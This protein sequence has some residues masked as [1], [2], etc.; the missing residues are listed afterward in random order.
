MWLSSEYKKMNLV[1][2]LIL[3]SYRVGIFGFAASPALQAEH[4]LNSGLLDQRLGLDWVQ[5]N[6][7][8]FGGDPAQVTIFG[9]SAGAYSVGM[10]V[11]S[12]GGDRPVPFKRA[13]M[14][15][16]S[17][18]GQTGITA[19]VAFNHTAMMTSLTNCT[20][21]DHCS[22]TELQ[23][24]RNLPLS[25]LLQTV[26]PFEFGI[27]PFGAF[28]VWPPT[29]PSAF[30]P[31]APS[32]LLHKGK[33]AKN[34]DLISGWCENDGS[35]FVTA[36]VNL[37]T[38]KE[39]LSYFK[40]TYPGL[41]KLSLQQM[42]LLYPV[43]SFSSD[44]TGTPTSQYFR[45]AQIDRDIHF[46]CPALLMTQAMAN[47]S[48]HH[49]TTFVYTLNETLFA[50]A[51]SESGHGYYGV[52]HLSDI[53]YVFN[54]ASSYGALKADLDLASRISGSWVAFARTGM[55][56]TA[57]SDGELTIENWKQST[58]AGANGTMFSIDV[59]GGP[60]PGMT[61]IRSTGIGGPLHHENIALRCLFW[62][63]ETVLE[64]LAT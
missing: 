39:L 23:C 19:G 63:Q 11:L 27:N 50:N 10:Q 47:F 38:D 31:D 42:L 52:S 14:E 51:F 2:V 1:W 20:S 55:S 60:H 3:R 49:T 32:K 12:Y 13:I 46:T 36:T 4:S 29:A 28:N 18:S 21:P 41:T 40:S 57:E 30:I 33:F 26:I 53:P 24:L 22:S 61:E 9:E 59:L 58:Q 7:Q 56:S 35:L 17:A 48:N 54:Q 37:T 34:I 64:E 15:S 6:I 16:G 8:A 5:Q 45:A 62:N 43:S 25:D 44:V